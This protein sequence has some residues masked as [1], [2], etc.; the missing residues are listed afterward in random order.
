LEDVL[1][2]GARELCYTTT[3][4]NLFSGLDNRK[5][6]YLPAHAGGGK[7]HGDK[8]KVISNDAPNG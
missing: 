3:I 2:K 4:N 8:G 5:Y 1:R 6:R 7:N